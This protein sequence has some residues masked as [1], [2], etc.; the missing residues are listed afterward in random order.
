MRF[1]DRVDAGKRLAARLGDLADQD[2]V[3]VALPRGGVPVGA[4]VARAL[5]LPL[6]VIVVRKLGVPYQPELGMGAVGEGGVRVLNDEVFAH[7]GVTEPELERVEAA[8]RSELDRRVERYRDKWARLDLSGRVAVVVDDGIATGGTARAAVEI[9]RAQGAERVVLAVP[10]APVETVRDLEPIVDELVCLE[11][12]SMMVA[13]GAWYEDF[14]QTSDEEVVALLAEARIREGHPSES[15]EHQVSWDEEVTI[16]VDRGEVAGH[17]SVP[18]SCLG[19][20]LFAHGSGS[21]RHSPRNQAVAT[22][23]RAVG[24]GTLLFDLLTP[25]EEMDRANV[26]DIDTLA[27]R[28]VLATEWVN[29]HPRS[30]GL[31]IGYFGAS[32]GA[33]AALA[34]A[35]EL[36]P[37]I[38]AVVSRGGRPDLALPQLPAVRAP[39]LL[40]VG[41]N[42]P[43]VLELNREAASR[44]SCEHQLRVVP[45]ATHLFEERGA[46][47]VVAQ[48]ARDWFVRHLSSA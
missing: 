26:F 16:P 8:E 37:T 6:D 23:L 27:R 35:A 1:R 44:L 34:A 20:V 12:P 2:A 42:D 3:V 7:A 11:T 39:T 32:T 43:A 48:L 31:A 24:L 22:S 29:E 28:L 14:S 30:R 33:A 18:E 25:Q 47:E 15:A 40:I 13:I 4:E 21:S 36:G 5:D 9:A 38:R 17:V 45:G 41:G 10:V 46:L 19:L